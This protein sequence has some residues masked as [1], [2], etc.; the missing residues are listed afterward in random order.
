V[1]DFATEMRNAPQ[2]WSQKVE[3][4]AHRVDELAAA[5]PLAQRH[6]RFIESLRRGDSVYVIPFRRDGIVERL[7]QK[8]QT[9]VVLVDSK[10]VE[11]SFQEISRPERS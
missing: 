7:R 6:A 10:E 3:G 8:R 5:T 2:T 4:L 1:G 9:V 11:V